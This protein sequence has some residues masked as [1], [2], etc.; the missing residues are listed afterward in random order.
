MQSLQQVVGAAIAVIDLALMAAGETT[1]TEHMLGPL[2]EHVLMP[3]FQ[4]FIDFV[5]DIMLSLGIDE[6]TANI[7]G[8]VFGAVAALALIIGSAVALKNVAGLASKMGPLFSK[9]GSMM[10]N[11]VSKVA[12]EALKNAGK[13][14]G[15]AMKSFQGQV[16]N[17]VDNMSLKLNLGGANTAYANALAQTGKQSA[18]VAARDLALQTGRQ[19]LGTAA[20]SANTAVGLIG[21]S[22]MAG[23]GIATSVFQY[24]GQLAHEFIVALQ[25]ASQMTRDLT[26][27]INE[28]LSEMFRVSQEMIQTALSAQQSQQQTASAIINNMAKGFK[29]MS[30]IN[31]QASINHVHIENLDASFEALKREEAASAKTSV[32]RLT[33]EQLTQSFHMNQ[34]DGAASQ[35]S[36]TNYQP[37]MSSDVEVDTGKLSAFLGSPAFSSLQES[38]MHMLKSAMVMIQSGIPFE[39]VLGPIAMAVENE[40]QKAQLQK[41]IAFLDKIAYGGQ[42]GELA[43][44]LLGGEPEQGLEEKLAKEASMQES[45]AGPNENVQIFHMKIL[46][47]GTIACFDVD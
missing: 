17:L 7:L 14:V 34:K 6:H 22:A 31:G 21:G 39:S 1:L 44:L 27:S 8:M 30:A 20:Q 23:S 2:M 33:T 18:A 15:G 32:T 5:T 38:E 9:L 16:S 37:S 28:Y 4:M 45:K 19:T 41:M 25:Q 29:V 40:E 11:A 43:N 47:N 36:I 26:D 12:P 46:D 10:G 24:E 13:A 42:D 3:F 35:V